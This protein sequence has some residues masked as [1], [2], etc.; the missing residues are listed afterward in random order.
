[1]QQQ[2][3]QTILERTLNGTG[4]SDQHLLSLFSIAVSIQAKSILELGVRDGNTTLPLLLAASYTGGTVESVDI[5]TTSFQC[6]Q[7]WQNQWQFTQGD[8][9]EYLQQQAVQGKKYDLIF[10][11]DWHAYD[12][13]RRELELIDQLI[14]PS[15]VVLLHDLM[16]GGTC[17]YYHVDLTPC[18]PQWANGG[19]YRAVAELNTNFWEFATIPVCNGLTVLRKKYS[20]R[21]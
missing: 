13:V 21:Y 8:V 15:S 19:P 18:S 12:H 16:Y 7:E 10:V 4:D 9:L 2:I 20:T 5:N 1:M 17:P 3:Y 6:P 11:D 14:K